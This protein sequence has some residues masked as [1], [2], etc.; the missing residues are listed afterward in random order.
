[1]EGVEGVERQEGV[2]LESIVA[3]PCPCPCPYILITLR[4]YMRIPVYSPLNWGV[5]GRKC[6]VLGCRVVGE[7]VRGLVLSALSCHVK[8]K[9]PHVCSVVCRIVWKYGDYSS[10]HYTY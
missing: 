4:V 8:C 5:G 10:P 3:C 6:R 1:M 2:A 9:N 7:G